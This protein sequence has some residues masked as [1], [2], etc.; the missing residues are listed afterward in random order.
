MKL[1]KNKNP[2]SPRIYIARINPFRALPLGFTFPR[3]KVQLA[4]GFGA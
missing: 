2:G 1:N 4:P 3:R